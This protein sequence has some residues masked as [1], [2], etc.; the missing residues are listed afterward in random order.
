MY[1]LSTQTKRQAHF[2]D[3]GSKLAE[4][5]EDVGALACSTRN[6]SS[7]EEEREKGQ[8][9]G[10]C[11]ELNLNFEFFADAT[12]FTLCARRCKTHLSRLHNTTNR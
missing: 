4:I 9:P 7:C 5:Y 10:S 3:M 12:L 6:I 11:V 2:R 8:R 1:H